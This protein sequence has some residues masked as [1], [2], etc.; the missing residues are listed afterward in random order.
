MIRTS[1]FPQ[2]KFL[3][4]FGDRG[5]ALYCGRNNRDEVLAAI[6][7]LTLRSNPLLREASCA[8]SMLAVGGFLT[9]TASNNPTRIVCCRR[10]THHVD[11]D[12]LQ[13]RKMG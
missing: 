7:V 1:A 11:R 5:E 8:P 12:K 3:F 9:C 10:F 4:N 6:A 2:A 13:M